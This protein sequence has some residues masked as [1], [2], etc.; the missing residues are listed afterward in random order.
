M[1]LKS[2]N[3]TKHYKW[4][5][6]SLKYFAKMAKV[7]NVNAQPIHACLEA[8]HK[9][10]VIAFEH[11]IR[12]CKEAHVI[13]LAALMEERCALW[14]LYDIQNENVGKGS[15]NIWSGCNGVDS[16]NAVQ[17]SQQGG[18]YKYYLIQAHRSYQSWGAMKKVS[19][20][21]NRYE[22]LNNGIVHDKSAVASTSG[23]SSSLRIPRTVRGSSSSA[24]F[25]SSITTDPSSTLHPSR[26]RRREKGLEDSIDDL[27][28]S[29][30]N[31]DNCVI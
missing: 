25:R 17:A 28:M 24:G 7:G 30:N 26:R 27:T 18:D 1:I 2:N 29:S 16:C 15:N 4:A 6:L 5:S 14:M 13:N 19:Q 21:K 31:P 8:L 23:K 22:F 10:K 3:K 9:P 12:L 11:A 20:F